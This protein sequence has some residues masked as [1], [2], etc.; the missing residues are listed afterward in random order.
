M[1]WHLIFHSHAF[2]DHKKIFLLKIYAFLQSAS[3]NLPITLI[4]QNSYQSL[5]HLKGCGSI[6]KQFNIDSEGH[7]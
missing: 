4:G 7:Q 5:S 2:F 6:N 1:D 3:A